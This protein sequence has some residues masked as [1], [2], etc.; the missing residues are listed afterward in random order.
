MAK[1]GWWDNSI[2]GAFPAILF[3]S[4]RVILLLI[5]LL[6]T[7]RLALTF[8]RSFYFECP[9]MKCPE[10]LLLERQDEWRIY[11]HAFALL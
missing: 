6:R 9:W 2:R 7:E 5:Y 1:K 4:V 10:L 3:L 11:F 8:E